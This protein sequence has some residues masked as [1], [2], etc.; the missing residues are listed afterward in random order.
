MLGYNK[1]DNMRKCK[2][3][4]KSYFNSF[5]LKMGMLTLLLPLAANGYTED[6]AFYFDSG[7]TAHKFHVPKKFKT[8]RFGTDGDRLFKD[9]SVGVNFIFGKRFE[10][11]GMETGYT[12]LGTQDYKKSFYYMNSQ[13]NENLKHEN[14]NF[15]VD[16]NNYFNLRNN[17]ELKTA[18]GLGVL[19]TKMTYKVVDQYDNKLR[20][21]S[22][23]SEAEVKPRIG[24]GLQYSFNKDWSANL[25][26]RYQ[27]GNQYYRNIRATALNFTYRI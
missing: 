20:P 27:G 2:L 5:L 25:D 21:I 14:S 13:I 8:T 12:V 19:Q 22:K 1:I 11:V 10:N 24:A 6:N 9:D 3:M 26:L 7:V 16:F 4:N 15:Y 18:I 23:N 17:L